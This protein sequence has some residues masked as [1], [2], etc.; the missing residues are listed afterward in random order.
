MS[1]PLSLILAI[2]VAAGIAAAAWRTRA[3]TLSGAA[4]ATVVG[5][6]AVG[7]SPAWGAFLVLWFASTAALSRAGRRRKARHVGE[8][9]AKGG[10]RD[11]RQVLANGGAFTLLLLGVWW[12]SADATRSTALGLGRLS[13]DASL[14]TALGV[15]GAETARLTA[16]AVG[17][18]AALAAA[19]ADTWATETGTW[20]RA[21]AWS[22][23]TGRVV[24]AGTSGAITLPGTTGLVVGATCWACV[25]A[26]L[27]LVPWAATWA[28]AA[29]GVAGATADTIVGAWW[30]VRRRCPA[31]AAA[32]EQDPH[33]CGTATHVTGGLPWL[34]NDA[35]NL[36]ATLVGAGAAIAVHA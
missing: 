31:C 35:V 6:V 36:L 12:L 2:A 7:V 8:M 34:D 23:R 10:A 14:S 13:A 17:A 18:A 15:S 19:G 26:L 28:V 29:G 25:A 22:L 16:L 5:S 1:S 9:V 27:G 24:P 33:A 20:A 3:L 21:T 30:Q 32:T 4:A 11:A